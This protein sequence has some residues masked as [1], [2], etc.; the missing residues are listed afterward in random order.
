M[1]PRIALAAAAVLASSGALLMTA[2]APPAGA[3]DPGTVQTVVVGGPSAAVLPLQ[4]D[5]LYPGV[6]THARF[7]VRRGSS[8]S[9]GTFAAAVADV[10]DLERGC[11]R[12]EQNAGDVTCGAGSDQG[13]LSDQLLVNA[14]WSSDVAGC[15]TAPIPA[16]GTS[17]Q[18]ASGVP[19]VPPAALA[20]GDACLVL[21]LHLPIE[22]DNLVQSDLV[23]FA[24]RIGLQDAVLGG[25][26]VPPTDVRGQAS[27]S[28][29]PS[30]SPTPT[31][32]T[33]PAATPTSDTASASASPIA[34]TDEQAA[35]ASTA[36]P[37]AEPS[38]SAPPIAVIAQQPRALPFTGGQP[39]LLIG[40]G[41]LLVFAGH[42]LVR[43]ARQRRRLA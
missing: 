25:L 17:M 22:A 1:T 12:P 21:A 33:T 14:G 4:V 3:L 20:A 18:L 31:A 13:E 24:L 23:R 6:G 5:R 11:N 7:V 39:L 2:T 36:A 19:F 8:W 32:T 40:W 29:S 26:S 42:V 35:E 27:T 38:S 37:S 10:E 9:G 28:P 15:A 34:G 43:A 16:A 41:A 30:S